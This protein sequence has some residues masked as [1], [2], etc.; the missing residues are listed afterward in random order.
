MVIAHD[1]D[2]VPCDVWK[3]AICAVGADQKVGWDIAPSSTTTTLQN[4]RPSKSSRQVKKTLTPA[5]AVALAKLR[6]K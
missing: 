3:E 5:Q 2:I 1:D 4:K 6:K